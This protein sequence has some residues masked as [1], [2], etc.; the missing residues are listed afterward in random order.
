M[1]REI[2]K[3]PPNWK[4]PERNQETDRYGR[5]GFQPMFDEEF[6]PVFSRWLAEFD[7][8]RA[9]NLTNKEREYWPNGLQ[10]WLKDEG[11][12]PDPEYYRPYSDADATWLQLYET[13]SEGTPVSPA[14]ATPDEL[15]EYLAEYGDFWDQ[16]RCQ[17][18][19]WSTFWGGEPGVSGWG[20]ERATAF[21]NAGWAP[22][23]V[24]SSA[25]ISAGKLAVATE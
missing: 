24:V 18:A 23:F 16:K 6:G 5:G 12:P 14:F 22:S 9:G 1:G 25:G 15:I 11:F 13:V 20:K 2:R 10:D 21:V 8:V 19:D 3:V 4:H 17:R 7:R